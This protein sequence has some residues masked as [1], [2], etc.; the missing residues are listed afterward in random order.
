MYGKTK[1]N[2]VKNEKYPS[3]LKGASIGYKM[4]E[5]RFHV[6]WRPA[7]TP[8]K[9]CEAIIVGQNRKTKGI[10]IKFWRQIVKND[11]S[12]RLLRR[13]MILVS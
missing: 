5:N 10:P 12:I 1:K 3:K 13:L 6:V 7:S 4:R 8:V 11:M 2:K 9:R